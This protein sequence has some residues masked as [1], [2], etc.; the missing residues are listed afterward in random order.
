MMYV[1]TKN[2]N[3]TTQ[4]LTR[5]KSAE[6]VSHNGALT[7]CAVDSTGLIAD[8]SYLLK[9]LQWRGSIQASSKS[10]LLK[11]LCNHSNSHALLQP[12]TMAITSCDL[13]TA[14]STLPINL[15]SHSKLPTDL[16]SPKHQLSCM[17]GS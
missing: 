6:L 2:R 12:S 14:T 1:H 4:P 9:R 7:G 11:Q 16:L 15:S 8:F 17:A 3:Y 13:Q 10:K 5:H